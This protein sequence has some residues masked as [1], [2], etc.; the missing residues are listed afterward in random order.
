MNVPQ[1]VY[2]SI[3]RYIVDDNSPVGI[4]AKK[5]HILIIHKLMEIEKRLDNLNHNIG[6]KGG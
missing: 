6:I 4:N 5:T 1:E 3:E 2:E